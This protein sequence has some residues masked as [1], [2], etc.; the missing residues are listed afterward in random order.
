MRRAKDKARKLASV[1]AYKEAQNYWLT[2]PR[3]PS[4]A[5]NTREEE[6][7]KRERARRARKEEAKQKSV[8]EIQKVQPH[9]Y[10]SMPYPH[11]KMGLLS[12]RGSST[13]SFSFARKERDE[14]LG[15]VVV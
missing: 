9:N 15:A 5:G 4:L 10:L 6:V 7:K 8:E 1:R 14:L 11:L 13:G 12:A 3:P 2:R